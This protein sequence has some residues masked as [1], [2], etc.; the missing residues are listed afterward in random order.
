MTTPCS[1]AGTSPLISI[2][3][4]GQHLGQFFFGRSRPLDRKSASHLNARK[5]G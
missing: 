1:S 3:V 5:C 2:V 4:M